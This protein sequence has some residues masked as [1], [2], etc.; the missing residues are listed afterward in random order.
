MDVGDFTEKVRSWLS[1]T[2]TA[3]PDVDALSVIA[4][5]VIAFVNRTRAPRA[6]DGTWAPE[7]L[8][9]AIMLAARLV[10]RRNSPAGIEGFTETGAAYV[11]RNDPDVAVLLRLNH[12]AIG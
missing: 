8:A 12:P 4:P 10:R 11:R 2:A 6:P 7:T 3:G 5:A 1:I 9:G